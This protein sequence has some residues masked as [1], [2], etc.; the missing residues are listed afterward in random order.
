M[1]PGLRHLVLALIAAADG[2]MTSSVDVID[3]L[4]RKILARAARLTPL[5]HPTPAPGWLDAVRICVERDFRRPV[6]LAS[7]AASVSRHYVHI[8]QAFKAYF[9]I[10]LGEYQRSLRL[11]YARR[12]LIET[13]WSLTEVALES[14]FVD[15]SHFCNAFRH[16]F[17]V[18][19]REYRIGRLPASAV[20]RMARASAGTM[21]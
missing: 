9:G 12:C 16:C 8:A 3:G 1:D 18:T 19:P 21:Q 14:G 6:Q 10:T 2:R 20:Q 4:L 5:S 15:Q 7:F 11:D 17:G 13:D